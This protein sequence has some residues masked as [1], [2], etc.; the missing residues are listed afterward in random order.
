LENLQERSALMGALHAVGL[1]PLVGDLAARRVPADAMVD[2]LE[3]AWWKSAL[4]GLLESD[5]ALLGANTSV[6]DRLEEDFRLVDEAHARG[7]AAALAWRLAEQ[8][9]MGLVDWPEE[10]A[11]L[12]R[13]LRHEHVTSH[14]L[15]AAAP[16]LDRTLSPVWLASPYEIA[17]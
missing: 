9:S 17:E 4:A 3:L 10:A 8:W 13:L 11:A 7:N 14:E 2:E 16:H 12:K 5:R 6:L 15:H 1:D